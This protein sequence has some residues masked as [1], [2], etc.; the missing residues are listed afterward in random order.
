MKLTFL[1]A[2]GTVT[3]SKY[4]IEL[5]NKKILVDCGLFQGLKELR[6]L[7]WETP[8]FDPSTIN[9]ILLTHGHL[10]HTGYLPRLVKLGFK[11]EIF[12]TAPTLK[13][14]EI[15]LKDSAKIQEEEAERA[16]REGYSKHKPA[17]PF[18]D[19]NDV[20]QTQK[21]FRPI[22]EGEWLDIENL[23]KV[24]FQYNGH[25]IGSTFIQVEAAGKTFVFSGD[26]GR[27]KDLLLYPPK[28]PNKADVLLIE[29]T[30]GGKIHP[31]E[32]TILPELEQIVNETIGRGGSL[33]IPSFAVERTQL[34]MLMLWRL[35]RDKKIPKVPMI[36]D[37]PMGTNVLDLFHHSQE[38]HKLK[39]E[40]CN[41]M[42][43]H[44][45]QV[46][47]YQETMQLRMDKKPKIVIAG[48]GM[49][50]GGRI[51]NYLEVRAS[52][53]NDTLLFVG[54][55]AEGTRGRK[56]L[57][58]EKEIK[59]YGRMIPF[60]MQIK[61]IEGLSAHGDQNDLIDWLSDLKQKPTN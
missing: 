27:E 24:I 21:L 54:Y 32:E 55:Q 23:F 41:Q 30:Y 12:A 49:M 45:R 14:A 1:G 47:N 20:E 9:A 38:W 58:G 52:N 37:S 8:K 22:Q 33:F 40:E 17:L 25:I 39:T 5:Q 4:L 50:T 29:S 6:L 34:L 43:S 42:C 7:N 36:M 51:L 18:S 16:N 10:D 35:L 3:G 48:S 13:I 31:N 60:R 28:K 46:S 44:F 59:I 26:I 56:L 19:L 53:E 15:I 2:A 11:G 61:K 57:E